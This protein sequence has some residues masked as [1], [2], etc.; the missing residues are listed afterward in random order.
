MKP[1]M[2]FIGHASLKFVTAA[3]TVVYIDPAFNGD[4]SEPADLILITH[5]HG[6]HDQVGLVQKKTECRIID[7]PDVLVGGEY[8]TIQHMDVTAT[9][10]AAYNK[11]HNKE[12]C[13]GYVLAFDGVK[14]Y[15]P[16]DTSKTDD[17]SEKLA[18]MNLDYALFPID[19]IYNMSPAE[20]A[21]CAAIIGAKVNIPIHNDP[22]SM[23]TGEYYETN[24]AEFNSAGKRVVKHGE[25]IEL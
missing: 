3:G 4:Y 8:Q 13:V 5:H 16:G 14:I 11:N 15:V 2:T 24:L 18:A 10:V 6:D 17:M 19:G 9:A 21:E 22:R 7:V 20:A 25:T 12:N 1:K 23:Q